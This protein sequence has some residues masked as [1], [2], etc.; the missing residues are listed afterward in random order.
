M[1]YQVPF[2]IPEVPGIYLRFN[3]QLAKGDPSQ[4]HRAVVVGTRLSSGTVAADIPKVV[5]NGAEADAFF[6]QGSMLAEMCKAFIAQKSKVELTAV[7]VDELLAGTA[8]TGEIAISG[9]ATEAGELILLIAGKRVRVIVPNGT[10]AATVVDDVVAA[11]T[12]EP[13]LP[14]S[15]AD[16]TTTVDLTVKWK[17][18]S[19]NFVDVRLDPN[20]KAIAGLT[21]TITE[22]SS[23]ASDPEIDDALA[24]LGTTHY[25]TVAIGFVDATNLGHLDDFLRPRWGETVKTEGHGFAGH[26]G[27]YSDLTTLAAS[28]NSE[29]TTIFAPGPSPTPPWLWAAAV[30][31]VDARETVF[32]VNA[33]REGLVLEG[34]RSA[35]QEDEFA[36][37]ELNTLL[38]NGIS[39]CRRDANGRAQIM[40]L[41][42]TYTTDSDGFADKSYHLVTTMRTLSRLRFDLTVLRARY[43]GFKVAKDET[44][45]TLP[46]VLTAGKLRNALIGAYTK[47]RQAGIVQL[48]DDFIADLIVEVDDNGTDLVAFIP[49]RLV[50]PL[51]AI[52]GE[53][54]FL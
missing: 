16:G 54:A 31:S 29:F 26:T 13:T 47:W 35:A 37:D 3:N 45:G 30:A 41:V 51:N 34:M 2:P 28:L 44:L 9:T 21:V 17:G 4:P 32:D 5:N 22:P 42:T 48:I 52:A 36:F 18:V 27:S 49:V 38:E 43:S 23:G 10:A 1:G 15:A 6:G 7:G 46:N 24:A 12:G 40:K 11:I 20:S 39:T 33:G 19:G 8:A 50:Y 53:L 25:N 14:V